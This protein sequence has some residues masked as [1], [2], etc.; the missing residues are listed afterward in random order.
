MHTNRLPTFIAFLALVVALWGGAARSTA[1]PQRATVLAAPIG[2]SFTYQG[3]L[4]NAAGPVNGAC[5]FQF[6]LWDAVTGGTQVGTPVSK[7]AVIIGNGLF[8]VQLDFGMAAFG[9]DARFLEVAVVCPAGSDQPLTVLAPRQELT[10]TPYAL[11]AKSIPFGT[12]LSGAGK[13]G[14]AA[15]N[16][17]TN[18]DDPLTGDSAA[19]FGQQGSGFDTQGTVY[20]PAAVRGDSQNAVGVFGIGGRVGVQGI[21]DTGTGV[22]AS[23]RTGEGVSAV[24]G[25]S[26]AGVYA[27]SVGGVGV[28]ANGGTTGVQANGPVALELRGAFKVSSLGYAAPVFVHR[29]VASSISGNLTLIDQPYANGKP[30]AILLVTPNNNPDNGAVIGNNHP[31]GVIYIASSNKWAIFNQ[32]GAA[33]PTNAAFNVLVVNQ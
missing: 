3:Q 1:T 31:I 6:G 22:A 15:T 26:A 28:Q 12:A 30:N 11:T 8:T 5:D 14:F 25:G 20:F 21:S 4:K 7:G 17:L 18:L 32:D 16:T 2:T 9:G 23:S 33:M 13:H 24:A 10:A 29:A 19:I 27:N